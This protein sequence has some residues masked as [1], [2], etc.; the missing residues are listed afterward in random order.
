MNCFR[1]PKYTLKNI[2]ALK[3]DFFWGKKTR[4]SKGLYLKGWHPVCKTK[5][6]GGLGF[7][8]I[9]I[10]NEA[11][12][13]RLGWTLV[14]YPEFLWAITFKLKYL[15]NGDILDKNFKIKVTASWLWKGIAKSFQHLRKY[16]YWEVNNGNDIDILIHKCIPGIYNTVQTLQSFGVQGLAKVCDL[17]NEESTDW[18]LSKL[19]MCFGDETIQKI[20]QIKINVNKKD[21]LRWSLTS[22]GEFSVKSLYKQLSVDSN[23]SS[24]TAG[25]RSSTWKRMWNMNLIPTIKVFLWKCLHDILPVGERISKLL[26]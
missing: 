10:M 17:F 24:S 8:N 15:P 1:I 6:E 9:K 5:L 21:R 2:S 25:V 13:T 22:G 7:R 23:Q 26:P 11:M 19:K 3:R 16:S 4:K 20:L 18:D 12:I 14:S